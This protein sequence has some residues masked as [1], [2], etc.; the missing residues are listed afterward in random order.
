MKI[1][2]TSIGVPGHLNPVLA[3]ASILSR[4]H[5]VAVQTSDELQPIVEAAG[6]RFLP[7]LPGS[8]TFFMH[9]FT[10]FPEAMSMPHG[11]E[12]HAWNFEHF[13]ALKIPVHAAN[14][15][16]ALQ[17]FPADV[18]V[19]DSFYFGTLPLL[20][21][22][23]AKRPAIVPLGIS[24]LNV[25]SGKNIPRRPGVSDEEAGKE[26]LRYER[27]VLQ[28]TQTAFD[29][30]LSKLGVGPLPCPAL[31][32]LSTLSDAYIHP[33][34]ESF[35]YPNSSSVV[36]YIGRLPLAKGQTPLPEWWDKLDRTK[37]LVLV[38]QGTIANRDF[39]QLV[40]PTLTGLAEEQDLIVLVTTG[41]QPI[42]SIPVEIPANARVAE[43]LPYEQILPHIDLL[44][45]NGGYGTVNM[46]LAN[47]VPIIAAG[48]TEDKEE[49]SAHVEWAGVGIDLHTNQAVAEVVRRAVREVLDS[50]T[51]RTSAKKMAREFA[52]C[53]AEESLLSLMEA[54]ANKETSSR[55]TRL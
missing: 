8:R 19:A 26:R 36:H 51:Y 37:R 6:L 41:G 32:S 28:P 47:G 2:I 43:F 4:H 45:T 48:M 52:S 18:I 23:R 9:Y 7:E 35:E 14:L 34:I 21:G 39:G 17:E 42:E 33:G 30:A 1:L 54:C 25:H 27:I 38:T 46:A 53:N 29:R 31:E 12:K 22:P 24:V 11:M 20:L 13:L 44:I 55:V 16:H 40:G 49:V 3:A 10:D 15:Q 50:H 5:E